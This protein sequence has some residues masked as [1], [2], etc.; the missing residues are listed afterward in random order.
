[1]KLHAVTQVERMLLAFPL[2]VPEAREDAAHDPHDDCHS[3]TGGSEDL[4]GDLLA[5]CDPRVAEA[6]H[7]DEHADDEEGDAEEEHASSHRL[8][9]RPPLRHGHNGRMRVAVGIA[10]G[11][12]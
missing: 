12:A 4:Q 6:E 1:M 7:S 5:V 8:Q 2:Q 3:Q 9:R 11:H 10:T